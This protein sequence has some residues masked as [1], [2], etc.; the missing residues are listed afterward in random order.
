LP[1]IVAEF[2]INEA[3]RGREKENRNSKNP[4]SSGLS[5]VVEVEAEKRRY[6]C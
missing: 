4:H 3:D 2:V 1:R 5:Y 6:L